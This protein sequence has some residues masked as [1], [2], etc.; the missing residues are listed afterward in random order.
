MH[1]DIARL[2]KR[3]D[4]NSKRR[5]TEFNRFIHSPHLDLRG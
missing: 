4:S 3:N 2:F 1:T 5:V